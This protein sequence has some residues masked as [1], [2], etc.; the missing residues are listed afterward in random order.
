MAGLKLF[1]FK[2]T[3]LLCL[4]LCIGCKDNSARSDFNISQETPINTSHELKN[5]PKKENSDIP[6]YVFEVLSYIRTY[7]KAPEGYRGGKKFYN[8]EKLLPVKDNQAQI[9][10]YREWDVHP[11]VKGKNRGAERLV[12]SNDQAW[13]TNDHYQSFKPI[14]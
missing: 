8:R 11:Y 6:D 12:T 13:Y 7:N 3:L 5:D 10:H 1:T 9:I 2:L 4:F 14:K